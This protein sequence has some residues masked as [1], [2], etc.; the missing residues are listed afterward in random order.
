MPDVSDGYLIPKDR[1]DEILQE[2][3]DLSELF[4]EDFR[5]RKQ[6]NET[7]QRYIL[8]YIDIIEKDVLNAMESAY[9]PGTFDVRLSKFFGYSCDIK[10]AIY[11]VINE[12]KF[13]YYF[14][15]FEREAAELKSEAI[16]FAY[17]CLMSINAEAE[18]KKRAA[19]AKGGKASSREWK[20][21]KEAIASV[22][23]V[24]QAKKPEEILRYIKK[25][26]LLGD[27]F[28]WNHTEG[29]GQHERLI[30]FKTFLNY[31]SKCKK[32]SQ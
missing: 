10:Y 31:L 6:V 27:G 5:T 29:V 19:A 32:L 18:Q 22:L 9:K 26:G 13:S 25:N 14:K 12:P 16:Q 8:N 20:E 2:I 23:S 1:F 28:W 17:D 15:E 11:H 24:G 3:A 4:F 21:L 7:L 30:S